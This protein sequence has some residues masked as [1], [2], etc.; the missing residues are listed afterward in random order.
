M[1]SPGIKV[2]QSQRLQLNTSLQ[3]SIRLLRADASGLTRYLEEQAAENQAIRLET[4]APAPGEWLPRWQ[5]VWSSGL[6][7]DATDRVANA[8]P[9]LISHV[10]AE[11]TRLDLSAQDRRIALALIEALEP[12]GWL[13]APL[14]SIAAAAKVP[15]PAVEF[16][17]DR[18]QRI[19][20]PGLF[21]RN[22]RE[23][24]FL[25]ARDQGFADG[26][27]TTVLA[28]LDLLAK[29]DL[30]RIARLGG[31]TEA[32]VEACFRRIRRLD[33]KPGACFSPH[34]ATVREPDLLVRQGA[35]GWEVSLNRSALPTIT[36]EAGRGP[37]RAAARALARLVDSRNATVLRVGQEILRRQVEALDK[38]LTALA[39]MTM[40][41]VARALDLHE[42]TIS[43][44][45][46]GV[47]MDTPLGTWW[48]RSLFGGARGVDGAGLSVAALR[49]RLAQ[50]VAGEDPAHPLSDTALTALLTEAGAEVARR[51]VAD[52]RKAL[53]I[54][55]AH[56]RRQGPIK[57]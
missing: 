35:D 18:V 49:A 46:A 51:T 41:D 56:R 7:G 11:I 57:P 54:P 45:V 33:P 10:V 5:G 43:R 24:L 22:L 8:A 39:P 19:D 40:A 48:L 21:A 55:P 30:G 15:V 16:V 37:G 38:G 6:G 52:Y 3:A 23:C 20:P 42:S 29:G 36:V 31:I 13:G 28:H 44:I 26:V 1:K 34:A 9:S 27:L 12:S 14:S 2:T 53:G 50:A 17:L 25:Q 32:Q 47:A 4:P